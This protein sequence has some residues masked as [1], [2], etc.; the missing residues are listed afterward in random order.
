[1]QP[2]T[3]MHPQTEQ[4][5]PV[6]AGTDGAPRLVR[7]FTALFLVTP[8][9]DVWRIYDSDDLSGEMRYAPSNDPGVRARVFI[10]SGA[11]PAMKV[12][13]FPAGEPRSINAERLYDQLTRARPTA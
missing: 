5:A 8:Q 6:A 3:H 2:P 7:Q 9:G 11:S 10:G 13:I 1:M 4:L 12:Y